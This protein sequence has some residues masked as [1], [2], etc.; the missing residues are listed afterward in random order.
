MINYLSISVL[1]VLVYCAGAVSAADE[2]N[3]WTNL[4]G[5]ALVAVPQAIQ[6]QTVTFL[7]NGRTVSYPLSVFPPSEQERLRSSLEETT[8][9]EGLQS[10]Y[11]FA[12]RTIKRSRLM[13]AN[14]AMSETAYQ[15][16]LKETLAAFRAQAAPF[17]A[18]KKISSERLEILL[19]NLVPPRDAL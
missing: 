9:P 3:S 14:G 13:V 16:V 2:K 8:I 15:Q 10:A 17:V 11:E 18:Q 6:G 19:K 1:M 7:Q 4:A 5:H 12:A